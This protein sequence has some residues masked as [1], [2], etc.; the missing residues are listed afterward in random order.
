MKGLRGLEV[1]QAAGCAG[2]VGMAALWTALRSWRAGGR[3]WPHFI[4]ISWA[5]RVGDRRSLGQ[6]GPSVSGA[7]VG[8]GERRLFDRKGRMFDRKGRLFDSKGR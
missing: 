2:A 3:R 6:G 4:V 8:Y 7:R 5:R 1:V